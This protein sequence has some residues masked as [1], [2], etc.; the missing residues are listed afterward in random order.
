[1]AT[2]P[3]F[4]YFT[5]QS[6][7]FLYDDIIAECVQIY[8]HDTFYLPRTGIN[9]DEMMNEY[10]YD[11]FLTALPVE[12]FIRNTDSFEGDGQMLQ[13]MGLEVRDQM[14]LQMSKRSFEQFIKPTTQNNRPWEGDCIY[15][16]MLAVV[17]RIK[18]VKTD[19]IFY[20]LGKLNMFELV[21]EILEYSNEQFATGN[22]DIDSKYTP[23]PHTSSN[24]AIETY[25]LDAD[26]A[27]IQDNSDEVIDFT[28]V[29]P[30]GVGDH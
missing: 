1:M 28:E 26:N 12:V 19:A 27:V 6:E 25:D 13:K 22:T 10:S 21:C 4:T 16:P 3:Y 9:K 24:T 17:Y 30:F 15:I 20:T 2:N 8:G 18:Y 11:R 23:F 7:Q 29:D 5:G 14:T